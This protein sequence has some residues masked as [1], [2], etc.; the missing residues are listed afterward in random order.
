MYSSPLK[1][2]NR[3]GQKLVDRKIRFS[4]LSSRERFLTRGG[5]KEGARPRKKTKK[6]RKKGGKEERARNLLRGFGARKKR[7]K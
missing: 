1:N 2:R 6:E 7:N 3:N 4:D 5:L